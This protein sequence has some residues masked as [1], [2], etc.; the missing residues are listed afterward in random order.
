V[1]STPT[2][3]ITCPHC[4]ASYELPADLGGL[5]IAC[6]KCDQQFTP[7][8]PPEVAAADE[9]WRWKRSGRSGSG[10]T[11]KRLGGLVS[12]RWRA[13]AIGGAV[14]AAALVIVTVLTIG[15]GE[16]PRRRV[17]RG[18]EADAVR[19]W[20]DGSNVEHDVLFEGRVFLEAFLDAYTR[21]VMRKFFDPEAQP[22]E[23][24]IRIM[25][26]GFL[27][28]VIHFYN[29]RII[30]ERAAG[31]RRYDAAYSRWRSLGETDYHAD[32]EAPEKGDLDER[33]ADA[34]A[35]LMFCK[36][37]CADL[38]TGAF[39]VDF[40]DVDHS[41]T[42][43]LQYVVRFLGLDTRW[44]TILQV[45]PELRQVT[46]HF[47]Y[48]GRGRT[49]TIRREG[50]LRT[51]ATLERVSPAS[52][53]ISSAISSLDLAL[54]EGRVDK[55]TADARRRVLDGW[56]TALFRAA[57]LG[58]A[59]YMTSPPLG[60]SDLLPR[61]E[62]GGPLDVILES[63]PISP[64]GLP[65]IAGRPVEVGRSYLI[66]DKVILMPCHSDDSEAYEREFVRRLSRTEEGRATLRRLGLRLGDW[67]TGASC[68]SR[69][70]EDP[71]GVVVT[72]LEM[73]PFKK[74]QGG[75]LRVRVGREEGWMQS[76]F[77]YG[78]VREVGQR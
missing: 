7:P 64:F 21:S 18:T 66:P 9:R 37:R 35:L 4:G 14:I 31:S 47:R 28:V 24:D 58:T 62:H 23:D 77:F 57:Y 50:L 25:G 19:A 36:L 13:L 44:L 72:V 41:G 73:R 53:A 42:D 30:Y 60:E 54:H 8:V 15:G 75:M 56:E 12:G 38:D 74:G 78:D 67:F 43:G 76:S 6:R 17:A 34:N 40:E 70:I 33:L 63:V 3:Q 46:F 71:A 29:D 20:R 22:T 69:T 52:C 45:L 59:R 39:Q 68:L 49:G 51:C 16:H 27:K 32:R 61:R 26:Q 11:L 55:A 10:I 1:T 5:P 48:G 65:Y 2:M